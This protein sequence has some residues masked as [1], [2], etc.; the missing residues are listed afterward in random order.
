MSHVLTFFVRGFRVK[1]LLHKKNVKV[2]K[3]PLCVRRQLK[4]E[5]DN[6]LSM[7]ASEY[8]NSCLEHF[9][10]LGPQAD[11]RMTSEQAILFLC[12]AFVDGWNAHLIYLWENYRARYRPL[13]L[14]TVIED[15]EQQEYD[16]GR[17]YHCATLPVVRQAF[18]SILSPE[19]AMFKN[20]HHVVIAS[21]DNG[22]YAC[23]GSVRIA[24]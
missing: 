1:T 2:Y 16:P 4:G 20:R 19:P 8:L 3:T 21:I 24:G 10:M 23:R 9:Q 22:W 15:F 12:A 18:E 17:L 13:Q 11:I 14:Q 5:P 7:Q 6:V